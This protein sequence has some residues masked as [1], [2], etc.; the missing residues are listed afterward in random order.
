MKP[1]Q[2]RFAK[3]MD[4]ISG[5]AI[6]EILK[7]TSKPGMISFAGGNPGAFALPNMQ[8]AELASELLQN[9]GKILL[10]YGTT[11][12]Y[13]PLRESLIQYIR[14]E[15]SANVDASQILPVSGSTQ[16]MDL[17]CRAYID[18]GDKILIENPTFLGNMQC[19]RLYEANLVPVASDVNGLIPDALED[20]IRQHH[21][22]MLY[23]IPTFQNPTGITLS[24]ERRKKVAE[25][26]EKYGLLVAEDDPYHSLRYSGKTLPSIKSFDREDWVVLMGSFSKVISPGLRVGFMTANSE[27]LRKCI[28]CKQSSDVHTANLNQAIVDAYLRRGLLEPHVN[29][30]NVTYKNQLKAML[31]G[32]SGITAIKHF[33]HPEGGLFTFAFLPDGANALDLFNRTVTKGVAFVPGTS[34]YTDGGHMNTFRLNFSSSDTETIKLGLE[35]LKSC[36]D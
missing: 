12:G 35:I 19:M 32:L 24:L 29:S 15:F 21:P 31:D 9:D 2:L 27:L 33:T 28:V 14:D 23:T 22:K 6:R 5:S 8:I 13:P 1:E 11:D 25:L 36:M 16:A 26:A 4:G 34:F 3:R 18:P 17:L 10:Q 20:A 7:L 30:I